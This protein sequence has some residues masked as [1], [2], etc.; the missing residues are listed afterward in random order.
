M[1]TDYELSRIYAQ[2]WNAA[3]NLTTQQRATLEAH[4][5]AALNPHPGDGRA[6]ALGRRLRPGAGRF[7]GKTGGHAQSQ[8]QKRV[9]VH[10]IRYRRPDAP[11]SLLQMTAPDAK[12][13]AA[14]VDR[15]LALGYQVADVTPPLARNDA[16]APIPAPLGET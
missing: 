7:V 5:M 11:W 2:G 4:G 6:R 3:L 13:A 1:S 8:R 10:R 16:A 15:L 9:T 14:Q 12:G